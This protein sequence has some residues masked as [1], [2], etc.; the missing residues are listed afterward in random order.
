MND[1]WT[2]LFMD[3]RYTCTGMIPPPFCL[4]TSFSFTCLTV[5]CGSLKISRISRLSTHD[6]IYRVSFLLEAIYLTCCH[7]S[8]YSFLKG[9][10]NDHPWCRSKYS[11]VHMDGNLRPLKKSIFQSS[12]GLYSDVI[13]PHLALIFSIVTTKLLAT[14]PCICVIFSSSLFVSSKTCVSTL[15]PA[16]SVSSCSSTWFP[17]DQPFLSLPSPVPVLSCT[18]IPWKLDGS[19]VIFHV[20]ATY[21]L[22]NL[23]RADCLNK[24]I[25]IIKHT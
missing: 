17:H 7:C 3:G 6:H 4:L 2:K 13:L 25:D 19:A 15:T 5:S 23:W 22:K 18:L 24:I 20:D 12:S 1:N 14:A 10:W 16:G 9:D 11:T 8:W 21:V